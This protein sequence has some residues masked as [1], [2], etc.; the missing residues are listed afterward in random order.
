MLVENDCEDQGFT[1]IEDGCFNSRCLEWVG[2]GN[3]AKP[4]RP[5]LEKRQRNGSWWWICPKCEASYG[6]VAAASTK[7]D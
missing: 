4:V 7:R 5:K 2:R 6:A 3:N 1:R